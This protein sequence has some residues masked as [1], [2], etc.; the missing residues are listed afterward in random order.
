MSSNKEYYIIT[1]AI[2]RQNQ[3]THKEISESTTSEIP[4]IS[5]KYAVTSEKTQ[6]SNITDYILSYEE[7]LAKFN[8]TN[9]Y[10]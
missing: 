4:S 10:L 9:K 8:S 3:K 1:Q 2:K 6:P 7:A 5:Y